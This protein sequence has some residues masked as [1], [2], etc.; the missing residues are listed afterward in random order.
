MHIELYHAIE[1]G[2]HLLQS[3]KDKIKTEEDLSQIVEKKLKLIKQFRDATKQKDEA[4]SNKFVTEMAPNNTLMRDGLIVHL[5][6]TGMDTQTVLDFHEALVE[7]EYDTDCIE[8][9]AEIVLK[10]GSEFESK[11]NL[12]SILMQSNKTHFNIVT[13]YLFES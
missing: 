4:K 8:Y 6:T 3:E 11:C 1:M 9:D 10:S 7:A 2:C 12:Y 13:R 5:H